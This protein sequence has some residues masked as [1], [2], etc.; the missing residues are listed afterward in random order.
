MLETDLPKRWRE[1]IERSTDERYGP[2][3]KHRGSSGRMISRKCKCERGFLTDRKQLQIRFF[4]EL[5]NG[6]R[7]RLHGACADIKSSQLATSDRTGQVSGRRR[8]L[9]SP[10]RVG[11]AYEIQRIGHHLRSPR[12]LRARSRASSLL[13][14]RSV[15]LVCTRINARPVTLTLDP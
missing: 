3:Y 12:T 2:D 7:C 6:R 11:V 4:I 10:A 14:M 13:M 8:R 15:T 1:R 5:L 9:I